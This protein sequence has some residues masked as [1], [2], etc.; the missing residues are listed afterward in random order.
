MSFQQVTFIKIFTQKFL[1]KIQADKKSH[2]YTNTPMKKSLRAKLLLYIQNNRTPKINITQKSN[3]WVNLWISSCVNDCNN[4]LRSKLVIFKQIVTHK[5][6]KKS[7]FSISSKLIGVFSSY[8]THM[9][10][11]ELNTTKSK[12]IVFICSGIKDSLNFTLENA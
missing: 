4:S 8:F 12:K 10:N 5:F 3:I 2:D 1:K 9:G 11:N 6:N 7:I